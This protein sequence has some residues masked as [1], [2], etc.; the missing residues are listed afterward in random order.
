MNPLYWLQ[1]HWKFV[2]YGHSCSKNEL[3]TVLI[4]LS[5]CIKWMWT[6]IDRSPS[7]IKV[8]HWEIQLFMSAASKIRT[9]SVTLWAMKHPSSVNIFQCLVKKN[10]NYLFVWVEGT[11][12]K[13]RR[14]FPSSEI[15]KSF[16]SFKPNQWKEKSVIHSIFKGFRCIF[17]T[18]P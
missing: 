15:N 6:F 11:Y 5:F 3:I 10:P 12:E 13:H 9:Q 8:L 4:S 17:F 1:I 2:Q 14:H 16:L 18:E 7:K